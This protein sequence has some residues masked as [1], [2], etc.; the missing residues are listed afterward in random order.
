MDG[1]GPIVIAGAGHAGVQLA[2]SLRQNGYKGPV[3]LINGESHA[4]YQRPPLSKAYL[5]SDALSETLSF[6]PPVFF[7][8]QSIEVVADSVVNIDRAARAVR[9]SSGS[10]LA[11]QHL[12]L[13]TGAKSRTIALPNASIHYLRDL[14][15]AN[16]VRE[17]LPGARRIAVVGAGFIGLEF[18]SVARAM[19]SSVDVIELGTRVMQRA[20]T[21]DVSDYFVRRHQEAGIRFHFNSQLANIDLGAAG[22]QII[23]LS[24]GVR[25]EA[26]LIIAGIGVTPNVDLASSAGLEIN[27]G[28]LVDEYLL[29]SDPAISAIGDCAAFPSPY[30]KGLIRLESIQNAT[31]QARCVAA[32]LSGRNMIYK[33][34]PWFWSD[35]GADK[36]Q[37]VGLT[38]DVDETVIRGLPDK[39]SFS[40]FCYAGG[41][42]IGIESVNRASDHIFGRKILEMNRS[43][44]PAAAADPETDL[45]AYLLETAGQD[46]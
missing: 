43:I 28:V 22:A 7:R 6:R 32:R 44:P 24:D 26:D 4:P 17:R 38:H 10:E 33:N 3:H 23:V 18:A 1:V 5:K 41:R 45:K 14:D 21:S 11:Y 19:G 15:S 16:E 40:V 20:V 9:L 36:L 35:Q 42:L 27:S 34:L 13:A 29:T 8:D 25:I 31:D 30:A 39:N 12:V 46:F 2:L 37:I